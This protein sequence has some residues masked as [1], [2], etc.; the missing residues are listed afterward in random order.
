MDEPIES[1]ENNYKTYF[2]WGVGFV[3]TSFVFSLLGVLVPWHPLRV[4]VLLLSYASEFA[5]LVCFIL[6]SW[7]AIQ[8]WRAASQKIQAKPQTA[9]QNENNT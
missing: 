8:I 1:S 5:A 3:I 2:L 4:S 6:G 9:H 7:K